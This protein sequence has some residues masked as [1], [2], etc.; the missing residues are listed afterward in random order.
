[1][2]TLDQCNLSSLDIPGQASEGLVENPRASVFLQLSLKD[3][4][5]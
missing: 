2:L 5:F 3:Y 4:V 1:M